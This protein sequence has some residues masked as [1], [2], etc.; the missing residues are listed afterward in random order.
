MAI[1]R[2]RGAQWSSYPCLVLGRVDAEERD[3]VEDRRTRTGSNS[4]HTKT[5]TVTSGTRA[6]F[7]CWRPGVA[8]AE[9]RSDGSGRLQE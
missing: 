1:Y 4:K 9:Q 6:L 8:T 7:D 5:A 3:V 2:S